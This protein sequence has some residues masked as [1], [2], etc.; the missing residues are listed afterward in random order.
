M[1][2]LRAER[3]FLAE[4]DRRA[5]ARESFAFESTLSG[6]VYLERLRSWKATGY[7]LE[8]VYLQL[9]SP[10]LA[11]RRVAARVRQ[12]GHDV[13]HADVVR[14]F[15]CSWANFLE[16]YRPLADAWAVFDNSG[17]SPKLIDR[18]P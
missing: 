1:A 14:R 13:P 12:G 17:A 8:I 11:T 18:G 7:R 6:K 4:L 5:A 2:A 3:L 9:S 10:N 16:L 15:V